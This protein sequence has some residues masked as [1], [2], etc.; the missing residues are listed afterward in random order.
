VLLSLASCTDDD[1]TAPD[2]VAPPEDVAQEETTEPPPTCPPSPAVAGSV[3]A[4]SL[5]CAEDLPTGPLVAARVGDLVLENDR[6]R[7]VVRAGAEGHAVLGFTGSGLVDVVR[8]GTDGAQRGHDPLREFVTTAAFHLVLPD[9]VKV[10]SDGAD[11]VARVVAEGALV[12]LPTIASVL[13]FPEPPVRVRLE[14]T[15]AP[16]SPVLEITTTLF[17]DKG[18][19]G[20]SVALADLVLWG[21][22]VRRFV[23]G[24][25]QWDLPEGA[26]VNVVGVTPMRPGSDVPACA[27]GSAMGREMLNLTVIR[28]F[29]YDGL[30]VPKDGASVTRLLAV[31]DDVAQAMALVRDRLGE[32]STTVSGTV[33]GAGPQTVIEA[34]DGAGNPIARCAVDDKGAFE[35]RVPESTGALAPGWIGDGAGGPGGAGQT[36]RA[37]SVGPGADLQLK[38]PDHATLT[39]S[40]ADGNGAGAPFRI[41]AQ[42]VD[43]DLDLRRRLV[44]AGAEQSFLLPPGAWDVFVHRGP[45]HALHHAAIL[46]EAGKTQTIAVVL[47][48]VVDTAGWAAVDLHVHSEDSPDSEEPLDQRIA[49]AIADGLDAIVISNHDFVSDIA[50]GPL[51]EGPLIVR[52]GLEVSTVGLGHFNVWPWAVD[53]AVSGNGAPRWFGTELDELFDLLHGDEA[54]VV[55]CNHPRFASGYAAFFDALNLG[56]QTATDTVRC[57]A[58]EVINGTAHKDTEQVMSEWL[59]L[60]A[61]GARIAA[62]GT[63]DSHGLK[64]AI[65]NPRTYV[66][67]GDG[68]ITPTAI[69]DGIR[70]GRTLATAGVFLTVQLKD[71]AQT[72]GIGDTLTSTEATVTATITVAAP[73]WLTLGELSVWAGPQVVQ[74]LD[75]SALEVEAGAR[76]ASFEVTISVANTPF[77]VVSHGPTAPGPGTHAPGWAV[78]SPVWLSKP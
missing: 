36:N 66:F 31:G 1:I 51:A 19:E 77:V 14:Y 49:L 67:V 25:G 46:L 53:P 78:T 50:D 3:R 18:E 73:D 68:P 75:V 39:V 61:R 21:G 41:T 33:A 27:T 9:S 32:T 58:L 76:K 40:V 62:T 23:P 13:P 43:P 6:V 64:D 22:E 10:A 24:L 38:A 70:A 60:S 11:L 34:L 35:C 74:T 47:P 55:Q 16:D 44:S 26:V 28:G 5:D 42:R 48:R 57:D 7:F 56:P 8:L 65:G 20:V 45:E 29:L 4:R 37:A 2:V 54:T 12:A 17:P 72:A 71:G 59:E 15:L 30:E 69:D 63:S 52:R